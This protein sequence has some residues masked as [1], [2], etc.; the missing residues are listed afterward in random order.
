MICNK[1]QS[2]ETIT[3]MQ[4]ATVEGDLSSGGVLRFERCGNAMTG[5]PVI[6]VEGGALA[7]HY[8]DGASVYINP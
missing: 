6:S 7:L 3:V 8:A 1:A 4:G 2:T 5:A